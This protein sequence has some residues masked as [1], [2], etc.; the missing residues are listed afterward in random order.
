MSLPA[1]DFARN[2]QL[3]LVGLA[4][5]RRSAGHALWDSVTNKLYSVSSP[6]NHYTATAAINQANITRRPEMALSRVSCL[7]AKIY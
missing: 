4:T 1:L 2:V 5:L 7:K 3:G 6:C